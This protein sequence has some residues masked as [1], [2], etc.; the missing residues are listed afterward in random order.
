ML[1][2]LLKEAGY[3]IQQ[4]L[5]TWSKLKPFWKAANC[6][7]VWKICVYQA[8]V[9]NKMTYGVETLHLTQSILN[10]L[11]AFQLRV[12]IRNTFREPNIPMTVTMC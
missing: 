8:V 11:S 7:M 2:D 10:K 1:L 12:K 4:S 6:T 3:R 5:M 9:Q